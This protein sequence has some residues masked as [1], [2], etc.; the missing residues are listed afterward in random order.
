MRRLGVNL[1]PVS[2]MLKGTCA[3]CLA[4]PH[5]WALYKSIQRL[6]YGRHRQ[7]VRTR[8]PASSVELLLIDLR[9]LACGA[10]KVKPTGH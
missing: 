6:V 9:C 4:N 8:H 7:C 2:Y 10:I 3:F 5:V 1:A